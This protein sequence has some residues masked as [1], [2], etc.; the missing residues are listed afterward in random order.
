[1]ATGYHG[2]WLPW[3]LVTMATGYHG[4]WLPWLLVTMATGYHGYWLPWLL[5]TMATGY[6]GYWL[7]WLLIL[8]TMATG[9]HSY[10][11]PWLLVTIATEY[12][13]PW[14]VAT[15][16]YF[17]RARYL[18]SSVFTTVVCTVILLLRLHVCA[19]MLFKYLASNS[20]FNESEMKCLN[21]NCT[22]LSIF[23]I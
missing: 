15:S 13:L 11:L 19:A 2:Y 14:L 21:L 20:P 8:V 6:H 16:N 9:Y 23:L 18:A 5:V 12:W 1:M 22:T 17:P 7:P 4:Y 10:W 3:L